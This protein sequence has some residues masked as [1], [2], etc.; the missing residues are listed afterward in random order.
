MR[1][2]RPWLYDFFSGLEKPVAAEIKLAAMAVQYPGT[3]A[4]SPLGILPKPHH[5]TIIDAY[6]SGKLVV[7][8]EHQST[9]NP[10]IPLR[11][12]MYIARVYEKIIGGNR[13]IYAS[14]QITV[15]SAEFIVVYNG[16]VPFPDEKMLRLSDMYEGRK[17]LGL[18]ERDT[19]ALDLAVKVININHGR[20]AGIVGR[21][22]ELGWYSAFIA[23]AREFEKELGDRT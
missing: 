9:I 8:I 15:P 23:K 7:L 13:G 4:H 12:L 10:N 21:C 18:P 17:S 16:T 5:R 20:N 14:R 22:R 6:G 1:L 2:F 11:M 19:P 3:K